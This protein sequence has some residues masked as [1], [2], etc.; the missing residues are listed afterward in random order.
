[1]T[2]DWSKDHLTIGV[3]GTGAMGRGIAQ[4]SATGGMDVL[5]HDA[6]AGSAEKAR[7]A[8]VE[9][10]RSLQAKGRMAEADVDAA[11]ARLKVVGSTADL[12][13]CD[14]V[15]EAI[16]E[17]L[18][19]K[20]ALFRELETALRP[21]AIIASNT[22]SIRIASIA[23]A[24]A[25]RDRVAGLHYFNPVPLMKLF[26][27]IRAAETAPWVVAALTALGRRQGRV[28]VSVGDT[29]GFL[30][31]L[32]GT[33]IG[34]EGLRIYQEGVATPAQIDA[35]MRDACGFRMGPFELMDLTGID[36]NFPARRIIYEGFF[37]DRRMTPSPLHEGMLHAGRLGRKTKGGWYDYDE[38]GNKIDSGADTAPS[39]PAASAVVAAEPLPASIAALLR[40]AGVAIVEKDDGASPIV[41]APIGDD[42]ATTVAR[43][44]CDRRR[45]VAVDPTGNVAA[46]ATVM[47]A[48]GADRG[49][50]DG[51]VA[52]LLKGGAKVTAINDSPGFIGQRIRGQIANLGCEMAQQR[53]ATPQDIDTAM[54]LGL[55][56]PLGP[57]A[58]VDDLGVRTTFDIMSRLQAITGDDR[59][60]PSQWLR[61][62]AMLGLP[63][64]TPDEPAGD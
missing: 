54:T 9:Q 39:A 61:R 32:G 26:E 30:V 7:A 45:T 59:Y 8:I 18:E 38:K 43:L 3:V 63:A 4:V 12:A 20:R 55:N 53:I 47:S 25:R 16:F 49:A 15:V 17:D 42:C 37:H 60:R 21:E 51:V 22:S 24:C 10:L 29:P 33:A 41:V 58:I 6:V 11:A 50:R 62:R 31:N 46:R 44:G 57:L 14:V 19:A 40:A 34:T 56:Y 5:M 48:P 2:R 64:H 36:V 28:P 52:A 35:V 23:A 13:P 1:M 27:V